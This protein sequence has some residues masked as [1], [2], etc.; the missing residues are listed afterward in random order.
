MVCAVSYHP[1]KKI[2]LVCVKNISGSYTTNPL[3]E[4]AFFTIYTYY[5]GWWWVGPLTHSFLDYNILQ[6]DPHLASPSRGRTQLT[7]KKDSFQ[8]DLSSSRQIKL[9]P[10]HTL[11]T[12]EF[13]AC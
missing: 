1:I 12:V 11:P 4:F 9:S 6:M 2:V 3:A 10:R 7:G 13:Q 8:M 5:F